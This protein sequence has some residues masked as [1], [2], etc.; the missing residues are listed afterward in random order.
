MDAVFSNDLLA[1]YEQDVEI[2]EMILA[3]LNQIKTGEVRDFNEVCDRL[4]RKYRDAA[5]HD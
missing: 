5:I 1:D 4:E 3:G 2:R